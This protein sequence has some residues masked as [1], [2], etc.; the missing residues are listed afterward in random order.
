MA[1]EKTATAT[2][3]GSLAAGRGMVDL[4][5]GAAVAVERHADTPRVDERRP[6]RPRPTELLV[7][8][9]EDDGAVAHAGEH[10]RL[11][12]LRLRREALDVRERRAV[13]VEHAVELGLRRQR[14]QHR[15]LLLR[16]AA[17]EELVGRHHLRT[18]V[19][20]LTE[21]AL[22]VPADPRRVFE[23]SQAPERL[24]R[25]RARR[26]VVPAEQPAIDTNLLRVAQHLLERRDVPVDV[27]EEPEHGGVVSPR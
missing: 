12:L 13:N 14:V 10:L 11:V 6:G 23:L 3:E 19:R 8:V 17:E 24:E 5:S 20:R 21:P 2:W 25:P 4:G 26:A 22:T 16:Q 7:A 18:V 15:D 9:P 1:T 27:V